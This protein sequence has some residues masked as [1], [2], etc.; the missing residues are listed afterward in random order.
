MRGAHM[1]AAPFGVRRNCLFATPFRESNNPVESTMNI[2]KLLKDDHK[3]VSD[4]LEEMS[5]TTERAVKKRRELFEQMRNSLLAHAHA[6]QEVF[7]MP[8]LKEGDDRDTMLEAE[9]EHQ[10]VERLLADIEKTD[11]SDEK[12]L[13]KVTVLKELIEHHVEEEEGE[14]FKEARGTFDKAQ[15]EQM[16]EQFEARKQQEMASA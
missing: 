1:R 11:P 4:L 7:Y 9:V 6:E 13:A 2:L 8:L 15:L 16:G 10:V 5:E 14:I 12:W 3:E